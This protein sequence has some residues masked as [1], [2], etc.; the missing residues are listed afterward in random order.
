MPHVAAPCSSAGRLFLVMGRGR[1]SQTIHRCHGWEK[2]RDTATVRREHHVLDVFQSPPPCPQPHPVAEQEGFAVIDP[3]NRAAAFKKALQAAGTELSPAPGAGSREAQ[4]H[5]AVPTAF[6]S[7]PDTVPAP[8]M[9]QTNPLPVPMGP[10]KITVY[11]QE[12]F[13][14]K[15]MEFTSACPNIMECGFDNIRSVKVECGAWVGYEHT[16]FCGQQF[17]LERG[18]YPRWDAWSGS[19][20][21]HI[22]R[23]MSFRP[24]CSAVSAPASVGAPHPIPVPRAIAPG[25]GSGVRKGKQ[26][27]A[28]GSVDGRGSL[29]WV[30]LFPSPYP[31]GFALFVL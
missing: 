29:G 3:S 31:A 27:Y 25:Q 20:A 10:W 19:N 22:E 23:L 16:G 11:D 17:I 24:V 18:E 21:Y 7:F 6:P 2:E 30:Q 13:Q 12:N 28:R 15:R 9:A 4:G 26:S 14:G 1:G 5:T 8:K